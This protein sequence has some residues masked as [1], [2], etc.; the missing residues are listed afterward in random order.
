MAILKLN[1]NDFFEDDEYTVFAIHGVLEQYRLAYLINKQLGLSLKRNVKDI[2]HLGHNTCFDYFEYE[3]VYQDITYN[4]VTNIC[5]VTE[6]QSK[7]ALDL[8]S[9]DVSPNLKAYYLIPELKKVNFFFKINQTFTAAKQQVMLKK[10][11]EIP[12]VVT[13]YTVDVTTLKSKNNLIFD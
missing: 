5:K 10:I 13:A 8:F 6:D 1:Y 3:N 7:T 11:L 4:L 12:Q 9:L 2:T